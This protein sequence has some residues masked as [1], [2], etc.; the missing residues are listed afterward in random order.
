M[1]NG[2]FSL[3]PRGKK[4]NF[5]KRGGRKGGR[6]GKFTLSIKLYRICLL[7]NVY[8]PP[9]CVNVNFNFFDF[10]MILD[11]LVDHDPLDIWLYRILI[12]PD[13]GYPA[14]PDTGYPAP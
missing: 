13:T 11:D 4:N 7:F 10:T 9:R 6:A 12:W 8:D 3:Y 5:R 14:R 1:E 2:K